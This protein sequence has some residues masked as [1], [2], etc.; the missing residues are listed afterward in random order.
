MMLRFTNQFFTGIRITTLLAVFLIVQPLYA[1]YNAA[2]NKIWIFGL[3]A[4]LNFNSGNPVP[5]SSAINTG[6]STGTLEANTS[7]C[8]TTGS[9]LFYTDGSIV[10]DRLGNVMPNGNDLT[11]QGVS[12]TNS[13][14]QG[15]LIIP[16][17]DSAEKYYVFS[18][19]SVDQAIAI[20]GKLYYSVV[21]M[22]LNG[23]MGDVEPGRKGIFVDEGLTEKMIGITGSQCNIWV[24]TCVRGQAKYKAYEITATGLNTT[25]VISNAATSKNLSFGYLAV[26]PNH[27][28]IACSEESLF[29][30]NNGLELA[31]FDAATGTVFDAIQLEPSLGYYGVCFSPDNSKL[32][33]NTFAD[34]FQFDITAADPFLTKT[35]ISTNGRTTGMELGPDSKIYF[36]HSASLNTKISVIKFPNLSGAACEP[37]LDN[38]TLLQ[39]TSLNF[40]LHNSVPVFK[41]DTVYTKQI[42]TA[43]CFASQ[44]SIAATDTTGWGYEWSNGNTNV[45]MAVANTGTY[46]VKYHTAPCVFHTDT[47]VVSFPNGVLPQVSFKNSCSN[48]NNGKAWAYT[49]NVDTVVYHYTWTNAANDT[50]SLTDSLLNVPSGTYTLQIATFQCDTMLAVTIPE[51]TYHVSFSA[52]SLICLGENIQYQNTSP[53]HFTQYQWY[54]GDN[55]SAAIANPTHLFSEAGIYQTTLIGKG[56]I[57]TDTVSKIIIVDAPVT[58]I[59]FHKEPDNICVGQQVRF[60]ITVDSTL[61]DLFWQWGDDNSLTNKEEQEAHA[62]DKEGVLPFA[63]IAHFRACTDL[64]VNDTI[65]VAPFPIVDLGTDTLLCLD[66]NPIELSNKRSSQPGDK[67]LWNTGSEDASI[68]IHH[69]G[70]YSLTVTNV[71]GC[72]AT[73]SVTVNK[74]CYTDIPN[75]FTP[76]GDGIND[77]FFPKQLLSSGLSACHIK[78]INR[79]GVVVFES[80]N[81]DGRGWDGA[82]NGKPQPQ[83]VYMYLIEVVFKNARSEKY[84]GNVT[85]LR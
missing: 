57:C 46:W 14:S 32:Y 47:F 20:R 10:R 26:S 16:V 42:N 34:V 15:A 25:P 44:Y 66:G 6:N 40:G 5:I 50:L 76:D 63:L 83:G 21:N 72:P 71:Y 74:D 13:T 2:Q 84:Q 55:D 65:I 80:N 52:D 58:N 79:W 37:Q 68:T 75:A 56:L 49:F 33:G 82:L 54:F 35:L 73:E 48:T 69:E 85:L 60:N 3:H 64:K 70:I 51:E 7:V 22:N 36:Q 27:K 12:S 59:S 62:Y 19:T 1:Q 29:A 17:P 30:G 8:D 31:K 43:G 81:A 9:L 11:G 24:L 4:G 53:S 28:F 38:I 78:I 41:R 77:Y 18:L 67:Y 39:G 61:T 23:G 45:Q